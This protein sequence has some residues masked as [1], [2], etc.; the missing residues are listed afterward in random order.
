MGKRMLIALPRDDKERATLLEAVK[1]LETL[2]HNFSGEMSK[3]A[4]E[5]AKWILSALREALEAK[6]EACPKRKEK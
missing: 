4:N 3:A 5:E 6:E 2:R 1:T